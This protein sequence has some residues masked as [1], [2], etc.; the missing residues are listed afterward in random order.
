MPGY[1][2]IWPPWEGHDT[3][4]RSTEIPGPQT[5]PTGVSNRIWRHLG[6]SRACFSGGYG[7]G[8]IYGQPRLISDYPQ[9]KEFWEDLIMSTKGTYIPQYMGVLR[10]YVHINYMCLSKT[11]AWHII[12][13]VLGVFTYVWHVFEYRGTKSRK[14]YLDCSLLFYSY[15]YYVIQHGCRIQWGFVGSGHCFGMIL[16][17]GYINLASGQAVLK[18]YIN[19]AYNSLHRDIVLTAVKYHLPHLHKFS[20][21]MPSQ[22]NCISAM[23]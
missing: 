15:T 12:M 5:V 16:G 14:I 21:V 4:F 1:T 17:H 11:Y 9:S 20:Y 2:I 19:N 10:L 23:K 13:F 18:L 3:H 6:G 22:V 8:I 7:K